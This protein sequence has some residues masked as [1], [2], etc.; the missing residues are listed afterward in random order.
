MLYTKY[1]YNSTKYSHFFVDLG[2]DFLFDSLDLDLV[3]SLGRRISRR[4]GGEIKAE[5]DRCRHE[6]Q[7]H[8]GDGKAQGE[9]T[10]PHRKTPRSHFEDAS[11]RWSAEDPPRSIARENRTSPHL[12]SPPRSCRT[13]PWRVPCIS[14]CA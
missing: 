9:F 3:L 8:D 4:G 14:R 13:D 5:S 10:Y 12:I 2:V 11:V 6:G 1:D 7:S